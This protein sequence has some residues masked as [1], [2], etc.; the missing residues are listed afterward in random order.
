MVR[1]DRVM[2]YVQDNLVDLAAE[3]GFKPVDSGA[4]VLLLSPYDE[5][6]FYGSF[7]IGGSITASPLQVYLDVIGLRGRGQEAA[8]SVRQKLEAK[9]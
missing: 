1:Y 5:G 2:A 7:A 3:A 9:W 6:V 8:A 4:N